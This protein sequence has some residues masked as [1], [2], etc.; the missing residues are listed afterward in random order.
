MEGAERVLWCWSL[1][2]RNGQKRVS[3]N[4]RYFQLRQKKGSSQAIAMK[5]MWYWVK[6]NGSCSMASPFSYQIFDS[7]R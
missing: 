2:S 6:M 3:F 5:A 1:C 4:Q 7:K